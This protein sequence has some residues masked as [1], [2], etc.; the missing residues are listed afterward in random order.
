VSNGNVV[1]DDPVARRSRVK[2]KRC[3]GDVKDAVV[4]AEKWRSIEEK[5]RSMS[6]RDS[7][8]S[9]FNARNNLYWVR[10]AG[11]IGHDGSPWVYGTKE[12][13]WVSTRESSDSYAAS[14]KT[15]VPSGAAS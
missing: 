7:G 9:A 8:V 1:Y 14:A 5:E 10:N 3:K 11:F 13:S 15:S 4:G 6:G 12:K 2:S